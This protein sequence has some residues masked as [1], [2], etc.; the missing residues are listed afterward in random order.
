MSEFP[1]VSTPAPARAPLH[2]EA[3]PP[4]LV[5]AWPWA[6]PFALDGWFERNG[7]APVWT[8]LL[9]LVVAFVLF[10]VVVAPLVIGIGIA[11]D[12]AQSPQAEPPDMAE[13]LAQIQER[14]GLLMTAN[15][16]GQVVGFALLALLA[17]H[18]HSPQRAEFLRLRRPD[19]PALALA[20]L[21][22]VPL[23]LTVLWLGD[24]NTQ[25]PLPDWLRAFEQTQV[26]FLEGILLGDDLSTPVLFA[27][28][29]LT[30]ALC[31]ELMFRGYLQRQVERKW[32]AAASILIVGVVFGLYHLRPSQAIPLSVL[33]VYMG[34]VVWAT[35]SLWAGVLVH[36]LNNGF[37]VLLAGWARQSPDLDMESIEAMSLPWYLGVLGLAFA[38]G[39]AVLLYKRREAVVGTRPDA[40][41]APLLPPTPLPTPL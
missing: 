19:G 24:L 18:L 23:Y 27:V 39:V 9:V 1:T 21:G 7:F 16:I 37:A 2:P 6:R 11:V 31:E 14:G 29:A 12:L 34:Y 30:P 32:G 41:P 28:L 5:D 13:I 3:D 20:A 36:L 17:A 22:W 10:Q 38:T 4:A 15:T 35:G 26:D 40:Q 8:A 33:G 25:I